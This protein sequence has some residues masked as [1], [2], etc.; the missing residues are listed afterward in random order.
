MKLHRIAGLAVIAIALIATNIMAG[1]NNAQRSS[2]SNG[3][4]A[5]AP[6]S[7][8]GTV[9]IEPGQVRSFGP[10]GLECSGYSLNISPADSTA[11]FS[12]TTG[13]SVTETTTVGSGLFKVR[14]CSL[15]NVTVSIRDGTVVVQTIAVIVGYEP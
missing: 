11:G 5:C 14:G 1:A 13:C 9:Y 4:M 15:G 8:S 10:S 2:A 7:P 12:A 6:W 3:R